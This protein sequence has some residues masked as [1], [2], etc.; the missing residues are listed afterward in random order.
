MK[1]H[2]ILM[3]AYGQSNADVYHAAPAFTCDAFGDPRIVTFNDGH[4]FRGLMGHLPKQAPTELV[5]AEIA[6]SATKKTAGYQSFQ[7]ASAARLLAEGAPKGLRNVIIRGEGRG[8]RRLHGYVNKKGDHTEGILTNQDGSNSQLLLNLFDALRHAIDLADQ[9]ATPLRRVFINFLHGEADR[10]AERDAYREGLARLID[11]V[12]R[13]IAGF[14]LVVDWLILDPAGTAGNGGGNNWPCRLA[15]ADLAAERANVHLIGAGYAYPLDD[16]IHY[17]SEARVLFGE[18]FGAVAAHLLARDEDRDDGM[19]W[20]LD[21]PR[22]GKARLDGVHVTLEL[23]SLHDFELVTGISDDNLTV[24]G[25][26]VTTAAR[27]KVVAAAQTGPRSLRVTLNQPPAPH[28][29]AELNYAYQVVRGGDIRSTSPLPVGRGG[30]RSVRALESL[31]L[32]GRRIHQWVPGFAI[33]FSQMQT[34]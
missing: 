8:G 19:D 1:D 28:E 12:D 24:E 18:H 6:A 32:P 34:A 22:V 2:S 29:R 20:L 27:C 17:G 25:F 10:A 15:M 21:A 26:S 14:G 9:K 3:L 13:T 16:V 5:Q 30:W 31:V 4:G 23:D 33:P 11:Q 7:I